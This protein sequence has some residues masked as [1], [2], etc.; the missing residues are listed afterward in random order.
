MQ[1]VL[2]G[3]AIIEHIEHMPEYVVGRYGIEEHLAR[4]NLQGM[5]HPGIGTA[6]SPRC[7]SSAAVISRNRAQRMG[8]LRYS[9]ASLSPLMP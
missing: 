4:A 2:V 9:Y 7:I 1:R 3:L 8:W 6:S 5:M